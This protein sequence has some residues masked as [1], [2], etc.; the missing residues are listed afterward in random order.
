MSLDFS[1]IVTGTASGGFREMV[2]EV[3]EF[4]G[5]A[6]YAGERTTLAVTAEMLDW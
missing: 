1:P 5:A 3:T 2:V 6:T 4:G